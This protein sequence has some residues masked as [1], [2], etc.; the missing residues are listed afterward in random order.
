VL[1]HPVLSYCLFQG[2]PGTILASWMGTTGSQRVKSM[3]KLIDDIES[4]ADSC[5]NIAKTF[6][7]KRNQKTW[8]TPELRDNV[9]AMYN[10][11]E[12]SLNLML[13]NIDNDYG[14]VEI[15]KAYEIE[16]KINK[17]R[18]KLKKDHLEKIEKKKY[19]YQAGIIYNDLIS[20]GEKLADYVINISEAINESA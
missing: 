5:M 15:D 17:F 4:I 3:F 12:E 20:E 9:N 7:R 8:F 19:K 14:K 13:I 18:D 1:I 10:L 2:I 11:V 6:Q 16:N